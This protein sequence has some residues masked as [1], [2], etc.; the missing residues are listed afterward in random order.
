MHLSTEDTGV[1][2]RAAIWQHYV[3]ALCVRIFEQIHAARARMTLMAPMMLMTSLSRNNAWIPETQEKNS[4]IHQ[5]VMR[6]PSHTS[7]QRGVGSVG[8]L[9]STVEVTARNRV[10]TYQ[11]KNNTPQL[12]QVQDPSASRSTNFKTSSQTPR[13]SRYLLYTVQPPAS[14]N[15]QFQ[16][17]SSRNRQLQGTVSFSLAA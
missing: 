5:E 7:C 9:D 16:T 8:H 3:S 17:P 14:R 13:T 15:R 2:T 12:T 4:C 10:N 11:R 6:R 1:K